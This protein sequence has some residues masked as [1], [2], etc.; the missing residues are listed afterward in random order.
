MVTILRRKMEIVNERG[1]HARASGML[2]QLCE[3]YESEA[4]VRFRGDEAD[5]GSIMDLLT[6]AAARGSIIEVETEGND[7]EAMMDGIESLISGGFGE[8]K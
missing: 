8:D 5:A 3:G 7:A 2:T 1:L 6:L 4:I